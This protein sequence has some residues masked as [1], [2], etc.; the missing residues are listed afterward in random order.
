MNPSLP[1]FTAPNPACAQDRLAPPGRGEDSPASAAALG[2]HLGLCR[3][4][5]GRLF[6]LR[7]GAD[8]LVGFVSR[9]SVTSAL[10]LAALAALF[11]QAWR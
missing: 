5:R 6:A 8:A 2:A 4:L 7:C 1:A 10:L 3:A 9:R 11:Y